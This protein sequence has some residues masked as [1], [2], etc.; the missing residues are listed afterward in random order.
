[1]DCARFSRVVLMGFAVA[2]P[3]QSMGF[4]L[5]PDDECRPHPDHDGRIPPFDGSL[6]VPLGHRMRAGKDLGEQRVPPAEFRQDPSGEIHLPVPR[7]WRLTEAMFSFGSGDPKATGL[8]RL[9]VPRR[10][11]RHRAV[12]HA[13]VALKRPL[14]E[15]EVN[16][17]H[18]IGLDEVLLLSPGQDG[19]PFGWPFAYP[20]L[21]G[22]F[23]AFGSPGSTSRTAEFRR[24]VSLLQPQ[25][26][27]ALKRLGLDLPELRRRA[28][29]GLVHGFTVI[30]SPGVLEHMAKNPK[31]R[32]VSLVDVVPEIR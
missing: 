20:G 32:S 26:A 24:W 13:V 1:M 31:A 12:V 9:G 7:P 4:T 15:E 14:R 28:G 16:D 30:S 5:V 3:D 23:D 27:P 22:G 29:E 8:L 25:D 17:L 2:N 19:K 18:A 10:L 11:N 6:R 21:V